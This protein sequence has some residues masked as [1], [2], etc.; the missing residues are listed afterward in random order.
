MINRPILGGVRSSSGGA[1]ISKELKDHIDGQARQAAA[2]SATVSA[3]TATLA[4]FGWPIF[5]EFPDDKDYP[6]INIPVGFTI[7]SVTT[8]STAGTCTVT[9]KINGV[10]LGGTANSVSS[11]EST[12]SHT[13]DNV[14]AVGD[15]LTVTVSSNSSAENVAIMI[16]GTRTL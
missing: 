14:V 6:I 11:T 9:V 5:I 12:Q 10:A 3:N 13:D 15:D 7:N 16:A 8:K 1:P 4:E 2:L